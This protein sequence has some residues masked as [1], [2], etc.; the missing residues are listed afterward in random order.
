MTHDLDAH[1]L[2][3][4]VHIAERRAALVS[5]ATV[6][7]LIGAGLVQEFARIGGGQPTLELTPAGLAHVR[8][9]DQ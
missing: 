5:T 6:T 8:S 7:R 2:Q 4:L 3:S 1:D 9:S